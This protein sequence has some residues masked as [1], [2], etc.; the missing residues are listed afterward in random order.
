MLGGIVFQSINDCYARP[1][2]KTV[3]IGS[4]SY[5]YNIN[6]HHGDNTCNRIYTHLVCLDKCKT[7]WPLKYLDIDLPVNLPEDGVFTLEPRST[8]SLDFSV[9]VTAM[10]PPPEIIKI[11]GGK[12][13][14]SNEITF[15]ITLRKNDHFCHVRTTTVFS[16]SDNPLL[17]FHSTTKANTS[18]PHSS[19]VILDPDNTLNSSDKKKLSDQVLHHDPQFPG[20]NGFAAPVKAVVNMGPV[21]S[22]QRKGKM[23]LYGSNN[24]D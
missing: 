11:V 5:P 24:L 13:R 1:K 19:A 15:P 16:S 18:T 20:Y 9:P 6:P 2:Q 14:V 4:D 21:Q 17:A 12:L 22:P 23:P 3:Y 10:W 8:S 7:V